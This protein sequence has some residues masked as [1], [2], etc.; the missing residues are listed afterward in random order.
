MDKLQDSIQSGTNEAQPV[1]EWELI[2]YIAG[3]TPR[4]VAALDSLQRLCEENLKG[5]YHIE[6]IDLL[7]NP[8]LA[9][10]DEI[11][12]VPTLVRKRPKPLKKVIGD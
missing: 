5:R 3:Q 7:L 9:Q 11:L 8:K 4:S 12:A 6:V 2:L 1:A 10:N